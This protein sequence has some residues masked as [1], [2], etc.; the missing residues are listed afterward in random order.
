[1]GGASPHPRPYFLFVGR[2]EKIKGLDDVLPVFRDYPDADLLIAGDGEYA[3][4][5]KASAAGID[6]VKFLGRVGLDELRRYY[7]HAIALIVPS[8]CFE[9]FG[10]ILIEAF[11]QSTPVIARRIGP[12]PEIVTESGGGELFSTRDELVAA[13]RRLQA[14]PAHRDRLARA[15][16]EAF[17]DRW[18]ESAV[19]PRYLDIVRRTAEKKGERGLVE[20]LDGIAIGR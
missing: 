11:K 9:T 5:L 2:L 20:K 4:S 19:V 16:H 17:L 12:F 10:I 18:C 15:G 7:E 8:V 14:D 13:M 6:R 3:A 1:V